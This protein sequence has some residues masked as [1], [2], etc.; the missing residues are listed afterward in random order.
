MKK[1]FLREKVSILRP[2]GYGPNTLPLRHPAMNIRD[3]FVYIKG[4]CDDD[5]TRK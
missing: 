3:K 5:N 4:K 1:I 2:L